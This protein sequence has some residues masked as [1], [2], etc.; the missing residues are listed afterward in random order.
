M[1][2]EVSTPIVVAVIVV[3]VAAI[4]FFGFKQLGS[5]KSNVTPEQQKAMMSHMKIGNGK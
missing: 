5:T 4:G 2:K 1:K 3:V